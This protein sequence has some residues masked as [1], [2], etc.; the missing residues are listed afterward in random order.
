MHYLPRAIADPDPAERKE[1]KQIWH[2]RSNLTHAFPLWHFNITIHHT[3]RHHH[4]RLIFSPAQTTQ[5][6]P[7]PHPPLPEVSSP[8]QINRQRNGEIKLSRSRT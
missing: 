2:V 6:V 3:H 8:H 1:K 7:L 5:P 4:R